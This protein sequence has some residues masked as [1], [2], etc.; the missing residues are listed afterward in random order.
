M[1]IIKYC[2]I[3]VSSIILMNCS[4]DDAPINSDELDLGPPVET[5]PPNT[6]YTPAFEGQTRI[7]S[8]ETT[9]PIAASIITSSLNSPWG[10]TNLPDGRFLITE[11]GGE[12]RIVTTSGSVGTSINGLPAVNSSGQGGLLGVCIDPQFT[13]NRMV[14]WVFS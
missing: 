10:I 14:Y 7:G 3:L 2:I 6:D 5:N 8:V 1:K 4:E 9:T 11:K 12:L 13:T